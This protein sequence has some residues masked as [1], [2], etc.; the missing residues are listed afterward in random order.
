MFLIT[1]KMLTV[2][3]SI[4]HCHITQ[5]WYLTLNIVLA[6]QINV[7]F[8]HP[9]NPGGFVMHILYMDTWHNQKSDVCIHCKVLFLCTLRS[10][11]GENACQDI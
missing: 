10:D 8:L 5:Y 9:V 1:I 3:L 7:P 4:V 2:L 11:I 6:L